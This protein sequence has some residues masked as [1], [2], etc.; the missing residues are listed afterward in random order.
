MLPDYASFQTFKKPV[1]IARTEMQHCYGPASD[2]GK[3][4]LDLLAHNLTI[5][6]GHNHPRVTAA[7]KAQIDRASHVS[8]MYY[9]APASELAEKLLATFKP[10]SDGEDWQ[11]K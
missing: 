4:Y 9:S 10:R 3:Q 2:G 7:A 6:V 8:T 11:V 1:V 5:S